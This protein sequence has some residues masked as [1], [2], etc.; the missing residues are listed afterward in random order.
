VKDTFKLGTLVVPLVLTACGFAAAQIEEASPR[1]AAEVNRLDESAESGQGRDGTEKPATRPR[2]PPER[3]R[4]EKRR[5]PVPLEL[6]TE[7]EEEAAEGLSLDAAIQRL[8][9]ANRDL[10]VKYQDIPKA[11][12]DI[13][14]AGLIGNPSVFLDGEGVPYGNYSPQRPGETSYAATLVQAFDVSGKRLKRVAVAQRAEKVLEALYQDA[15]RQEIDKLYAAYVDV[16]AAALR[17]GALRRAVVHLTA[18]TETTRA[19]ADRGRVRR[20][21]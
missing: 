10:A 17:R 16:L 20:R 8:L 15:V 1:L 11:R 6:P 7:G 19:R 5:S 2:R 21:K 18:V 12:A 14:S 3:A 13:L 9:A 4:E